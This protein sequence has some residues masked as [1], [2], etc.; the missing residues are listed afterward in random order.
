MTALSPGAPPAETQA[1]GRSGAAR[2]TWVLSSLDQV[3]E[4]RWNRLVPPR[5]GGLSSGFLRAW[6]RA[7]LS[8]RVAR[9][10]VVRTSG[11]RQLLAATAAYHYELD[12][13]AASMPVAPHVLKLIRRGWPR[14]MKARVYELGAPVARHDP[15]L[16]A[17]GVEA[18][19]VAQQV[20]GAAVREADAAGAAM[21]I[22]QDFVAEG[23]AF[24][25]ALCSH[26]FSR[27]ITLPS[28]VLELKYASFADYLG[29]MRSKYR[30]R[31]RC[32]L[33]DS[34]HLT[35]ELIDGFGSLAEDMARL[36]RLV[37]DRARETK[38]EVLGPAF[39]RAAA[40]LGPL[41]AL[42]LWRSD[43]SIAGFALLMED[44]D[45]LHFLHCG[46]AEPAARREAAYL[47]LLLEIVR[48]G[49]DGGFRA[50]H[51]GCTTAEPKLDV[52]AVPV[53]LAAWLRHRHPLL[54]KLFVAGGNGRFA[55]PPV[56]PRRVF[57][58]PGDGR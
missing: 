34:S 27:V 8:G 31:C 7:E 29:A 11:G 44:G 55:P 35:A 48:V 53:S 42:V 46:F 25:Q 12:L 6:E 36:W 54:Q 9:P 33:R 52:G 21:T 22:V 39:F 10:I 28:F 38:R 47:R 56:Q 50:V 16:L 19:S 51:L 58:A 57:A 3:P 43:G 20:V 41:K 30:R 45:W 2:Q 5:Q 14:L 24:D 37:Y 26:G 32:V 13:A 49:I 4:S 23:G 1:P 40:E 15:F 18:S 17:P